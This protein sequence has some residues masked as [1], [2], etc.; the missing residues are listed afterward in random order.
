M[1]FAISITPR[2]FFHNWFA[3]HTDSVK[4]TPA[5][6]QKRVGKLLL[7]CNCDNIVA[8]SP[9]TVDI[10]LSAELLFSSLKVNKEVHFISSPHHFF[11]LRGPPVV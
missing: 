4:Q 8:E 6:A 5:D 11:L 2:I 1:I 10:L 7:N 3:N 9:F